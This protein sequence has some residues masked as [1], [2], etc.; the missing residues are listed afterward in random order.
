M[1]IWYQLKTYLSVN[2]D[3]FCHLFAIFP[4][5]Y[6]FYDE[7]NVETV[8]DININIKIIVGWEIWV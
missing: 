5:L 3:I 4:E 6:Y 1:L 2:H 7:K 8:V